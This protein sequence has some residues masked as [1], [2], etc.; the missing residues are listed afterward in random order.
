MPL[1]GIEAWQTGW[2]DN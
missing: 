2:E 1:E